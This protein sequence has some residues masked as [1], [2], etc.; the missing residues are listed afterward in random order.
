[1]RNRAKC[2]LCESTIES[3]HEGDYVTCK[4]TEIAIEGGNV[5]FHTE[6]NDYKN[7]L[8]VDD[9]GNEIVVT[10]KKK[11]QNDKPKEISKPSREELLDMLEQLVKNIQNLPSGAMMT[12]INHYD[13]SSSLLILLAILR[14]S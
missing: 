7:F 10:V 12:P 11:G 9:Q 1:M 13:F 3:F 6:A 4:C 2:K 14:E 8:R 5:R